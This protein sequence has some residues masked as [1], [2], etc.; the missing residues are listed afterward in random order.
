MYIFDQIHVLY[1]EIRAIFAHCECLIFLPQVGTR[2][3]VAVRIFIMNAQSPC[4]GCCFMVLS[5]SV[6][7]IQHGPMSHVNAYRLFAHLTHSCH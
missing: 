1:I 6:F 3:F 5:T 2:A 4:R 7:Q